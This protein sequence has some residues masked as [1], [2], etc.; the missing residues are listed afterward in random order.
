MPDPSSAPAFAYNPFWWWSGIA[1]PQD[2]PFAGFSQPILPGWSFG[3]VTVNEA[4][5][6][7][8]DNEQRIVAEKSYGQQIGI[9]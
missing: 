6:N 2:R 7:A 3:N 9:L 5:S 4:N 8:P 1:S